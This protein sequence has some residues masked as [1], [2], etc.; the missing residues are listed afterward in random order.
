M[1]RRERVLWGCKMPHTQRINKPFNFKWKIFTS[2]SINTKVRTKNIN[3]KY[4]FG[5]HVCAIDRTKWWNSRAKVHTW[6]VSTL[7]RE[8]N[9]SEK[10]ECCV[11]VSPL[12]RSISSIYDVRCSQECECASYI[13]CL[14][15][16]LLHLFILI[17]NYV[18]YRA[19]SRNCCFHFDI[20]LSFISRTYTRICT[21]NKDAYEYPHRNT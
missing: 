16:M 7:P 13:V 6:C 3:E 9:S 18:I 12:P 14:Y 15:V 4:K 19:N 17:I 1:R 20:S 8:P 2:V 5:S 21:H 11:L 10:K